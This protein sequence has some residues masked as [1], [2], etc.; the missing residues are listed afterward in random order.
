VPYRAV[1]PDSE[2]YESCFAL[3]MALCFADYNMAR[4][5]DAPVPVPQNGYTSQWVNL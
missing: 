1:S 5:R 3:D 4:A 2:F